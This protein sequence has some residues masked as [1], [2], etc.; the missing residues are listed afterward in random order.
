[1]FINKKNI[2]IIEFF[3][4]SLLLHN[5]V[6]TKVETKDLILEDQKVYITG[7]EEFKYLG[8]KIDKEDK[9]MILRT[10]LIKVEE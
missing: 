1:V 10:G 5:Y 3:K 7:C 4:C 2:N 6:A 9:K 8:V